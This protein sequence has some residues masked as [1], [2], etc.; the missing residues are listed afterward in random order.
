MVEQLTQ[1]Q[2]DNKEKKEVSAFVK[3]LVHRTNRARKES[4]RAYVIVMTAYV[5][6]YL[7]D[8]LKANLV[9]SRQDD[10]ELFSSWRPVYNFGPRIDLAYRLGLISVDMAWVLHQIR[11]LRD[12]CAHKADEVDLESSPFKERILGMSQRLLG[13][14]NKPTDDSSDKFERMVA[15]LLIVLESLGRPNPSDVKQSRVAE[16]IFKEDK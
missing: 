1:E 9:V 5:D 3:D 14:T 11:K 16:W 6:D 4:P 10:D 13:I 7:T 15:V 12:D 8:A 2:E